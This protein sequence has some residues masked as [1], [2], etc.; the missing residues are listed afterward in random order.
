MRVYGY[1]LALLGAVICAGV[2]ASPISQSLRPS[3]RPGETAAPLITLASAPL[4]RP[5]LRPQTFTPPEQVVKVASNPRFES[6]IAGF[7]GRALSQGISAA[8]F[9]RAF[10]GVQYDSEVIERDRNQ[11]EFTKTIWQYL[12]SAVSDKRVKNGKSSLRKH[13]RK[14]EAIE[15]GMR[16]KAQE[17][18]EKGGEIYS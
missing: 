13:R 4:L 10:R 14:L 8:T 17:F 3:A 2:S 12:D 5:Q 9:D 18:T 7:R 16:E 6:W 15:A 11:S 1:F